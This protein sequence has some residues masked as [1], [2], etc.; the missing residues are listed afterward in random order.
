MGQYNHILLA[1]DFNEESAI[2]EQRAAAL[3]A[4]FAATLSIVHVLEPISIAYGGEFPVDLGDLH[5]ELEKQAMS[6]LRDLG[7]RLNV[8]EERQYME[9]GITEK[10]ILRVA[11]DRAVD[12]I[13]MGSHGRHGLALLLGSTANAVLHH[14]NIDVLAVRVNKDSK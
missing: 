13:V 11:E 8:P 6:Q 4:T 12:L 7:Q 14:A 9:V 1:A 5:K 10:E 2:V 3:Q